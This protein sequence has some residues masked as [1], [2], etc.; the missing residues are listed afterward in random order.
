MPDGLPRAAAAS[1]NRPGVP[2]PSAFHALPGEAKGSSMT[3]TIK[4]LKRLFGL[5]PRISR[6]QAMAAFGRRYASF[7]ELL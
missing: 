6:E 7:N 1:R 3:T 5:E 2:A 4:T